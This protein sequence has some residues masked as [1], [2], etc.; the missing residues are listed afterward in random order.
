MLLKAKDITIFVFEC[1]QIERFDWKNAVL[2]FKSRQRCGSYHK[3]KL[4]GNFISIVE[5]GNERA[6]KM[7]KGSC[8]PT[9]IC[10][11]SSK[12]TLTLSSVSDN[13]AVVSLQREI[14]DLNGNIIEPCEIQISH[15]EPF[16]KFELLAACAVLLLAGKIPYSKINLT[17][18]EKSRG[19][20][21]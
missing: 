15:D 17:Q 16:S 11:M 7:L 21:G 18:T 3:L 9:L 4:S 19:A 6:L 5:E 8:A 2:I 13:S 14:C 20:E 12:D 10:G 1:E